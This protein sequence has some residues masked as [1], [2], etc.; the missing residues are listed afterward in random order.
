MIVCIILLPLLFLIKFKK[1]LALIPGLY[2]EV[3]ASRQG[4]DTAYNWS[5]THIV[6]A[7]RLNSL[8]YSL[9][10]KSLQ[11]SIFIYSIYNN[12]S[13]W[14]SFRLCGLVARVPGYRCG[15]LGSIPGANR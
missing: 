7:L 1:F 8:C 4:S 13:S 9:H 2:L 11:L 3:P 14:I 6:S 12:T 10:P 5:D 15:G